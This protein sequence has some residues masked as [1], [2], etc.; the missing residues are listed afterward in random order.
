MGITY[1]YVCAL[2]ASIALRSTEGV[3]SGSGVRE[4]WAAFVGV[5]ITPGPG[6]TLSAHSVLVYLFSVCLWRPVKGIT[7]PWTGVKMLA[8]HH[9][10]THNWTGS[11]GR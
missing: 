10:G 6:R 9:V 11:S 8:S 4:S 2:C 5:M 3:R 7:S 1:M